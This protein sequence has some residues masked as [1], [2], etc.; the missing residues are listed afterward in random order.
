M[1]RFAPKIIFILLTVTV[2]LAPLPL[3]ANRAWAWAPLA[4]VFGAL[5]IAAALSL[6]RTAL[7][8]LK[9]RP[10]AIPAAAFGVLIAWAWLQTLPVWPPGLA[11]P[12][13]AEA[14]AAGVPV[15]GGRISLDPEGGRTAVMRW[16]SYGTVFVLAF[17]L[18]QKGRNAALGYKILACA[19]CGYAVYG[20]YRYFAGVP[21]ILGFYPYGQQGA[22][23]GTFPGRNGFASYA[24][25]MLLVVTAL[26][27]RRLRRILTSNMPGK[28]RRRM[29]LQQLGGPLSLYLSAAILIGFALLASQSRAGAAA[30]LLS[31]LILALM[32]RGPRGSAGVAGFGAGIV[33]LSGLIWLAASGPLQTRISE[34]TIAEVTET[35]RGPIWEATVRAIAD[36]PLLGH[37]VGSFEEVFPLYR[38]ADVWGHIYV[39]K[40]HSSYLEAMMELG[41]PVALALLVIPMWIGLACVQGIRLRRRRQIYPAVALA[42]TGGLALHSLVD[43]PAQLPAIALTYFYLSGIGVAQSLQVRKKRKRPPRN[44]RS[45]A[46]SYNLEIGPTYRSENGSGPVPPV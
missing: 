31:L 16:L 22:V 3:G 10:F 42:A 29:I 1:T 9:A 40:A 14:A 12:A 11:H 4:A 35:G 27:F 7:A 20:L 37:G 21:E 32:L 43:F 17:I 44:V 6:P 38:G 26:N 45:A 28:A 39:S 24:G 46:N 41:V 8:P 23:T 36:R 18:T 33:V 2:A 19:A 13:W 25:L 5:A 30:A 34:T 15:E